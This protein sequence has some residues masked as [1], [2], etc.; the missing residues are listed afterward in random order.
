MLFRKVTSTGPVTFREL[1]EATVAELAE[2]K[3]AELVEAIVFDSQTCSV[4]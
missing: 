1:V 3:V 4:P 2:A